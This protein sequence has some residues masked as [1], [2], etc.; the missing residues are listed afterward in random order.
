MSNPNAQ[1]GS[2]GLGSV[3]GGGTLTTSGTLT[4]L[5][6]TGYAAYPY[7]P[8]P[9]PYDVRKDAFA[10]CVQIGKWTDM[11]AVVAGAKRLER[12]LLTGE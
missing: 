3:L 4:G 12:Y 6:P 9:S 7:A 11:E 5:T 2:G 8:G 1:M 10:L